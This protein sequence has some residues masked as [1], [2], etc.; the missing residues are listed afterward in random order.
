MRRIILLFCL[1]FIVNICFSQSKKQLKLINKAEEAFRKKSYPTAKAF[2]L[3]A[4]SLDAQSAETIFKLG[5]IESLNRNEEK[6]TEYYLNAIQLGPTNPAFTEAHVYI[7]IRELRQGNYAKSKEYLDFALENT[8][9]SAM[10]Y[11]ELR[12]KIEV[13]ENGIEAKKNALEINPIKL[14][15]VVNIRM[16]QYFP[17]F[18]ADNETLFFTAVE[19]NGDENIY[20]S[21]LINGVFSIPKLVNG[22]I[23][24][25]S[26]EGTCS[27]SSDGRTMV[28]TSCEGRSSFGS[29]DLYITYK[30]GEQWSNPQ[31]IGSSVN[32]SYWES[33]P[34]LSGDGKLLF[35]SSERPGGFGRKDLWLSQLSKQG[36][37]ASAVNLGKN[38]NTTS[39]DIS[40]FI[41]ANGSTFFFSSNGRKSFGG[42]DI[43]MAN[44][45]DGN[46]EEPQNLGY[47]INDAGDQV[48]LFVTA[49]GKT[50]YFASDDKKRIDL[51]S[52]EI[53]ETIKSKYKKVNYLKGIVT[54]KVTG[55]PIGASIQLVDLN[56]QKVLVNAKADEI[57]GEYVLVLPHG[58]RYAIHANK[59][60]YLFKSLNVDVS[61]SERS[62]GNEV[63]I[64]LEAMQKEA[65][66]VLSN[67]FFDSGS[68]VLRSDSYFELDKLAK[69]LTDNQDIIAQING[70]TDDIGNEYDNL[71]LSQAR[72]EAV[73]AYLV[74]KQIDK[75]RIIPQGFG[76]THPILPNENEENRQLNRRIEFS[77]Q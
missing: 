64:K 23:N 41:H 57:S 44:I 63:D 21:T 71:T 59:T 52:F 77:I 75:K 3:K 72:A 33:Q 56:S 54:D 73:A 28:F 34:A 55:E 69:L 29:C 25:T 26:N 60:G 20:A 7:G 22:G 51:F 43:F 50:A 30:T 9:S 36:V 39:D 65:N 37:W 62:E 76:E 27:I 48:S 12:S 47:P 46:F 2:Y 18:T 70:H 58:N 35:F 68:A 40:P 6:A 24:S 19:E 38:I 1:T 5:K 10:L 8:L 61:K 66:I 17:V 42:F 14:P 4:L 13:C 45:I 67:I 32:S 53:P 49:D 74:L 15:E 16:K 31:N 11:H